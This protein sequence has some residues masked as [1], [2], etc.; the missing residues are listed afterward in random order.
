MKRKKLLG[1]ITRGN[2]NNVFFADIVNLAIGLGSK[3]L[4]FKEVITFSNIRI[5]W[6]YSIFKKFMERQNHIR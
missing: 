5:S 1:K 3:Y 4:E 2:L 6:N